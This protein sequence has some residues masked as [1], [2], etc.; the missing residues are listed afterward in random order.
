MNATAPVRVWLQC[1]LRPS[2]R[3]VIIVVVRTQY[4]F[5]AVAGAVVVDFVVNFALWSLKGIDLSKFYHVLFGSCCPRRYCG[6]PEEEDQEERLHLFGDLRSQCELKKE[7]MRRAFILKSNPGIFFLKPSV[8]R[9]SE[10]SS[11]VILKPLVL[12]RNVKHFHLFGYVHIPCELRKGGVF[13]P[14]T[15]TFITK[16]LV[17]FWNHHCHP[18][19]VGFILK[20]SGLSWNRQFLHPETVSFAL[21]R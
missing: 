11:F 9:H 14:E 19:T 17:S 16:P 20:P 2:R 4:L 13:R 15:V 18:Q 6:L 21:K 1:C 5:I 12:S 7:K 3:S 10:T 8:F